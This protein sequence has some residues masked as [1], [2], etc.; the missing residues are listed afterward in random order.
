MLS[1]L[2]ESSATLILGL[3]LGVAIAATI[4]LLVALYQLIS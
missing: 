4:M 1:D 2:I 3:I